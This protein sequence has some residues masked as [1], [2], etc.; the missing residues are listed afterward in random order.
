MLAVTGGF[1]A[2]V[3]GLRIS[4]RSPFLVTVL[5]IINFTIWFS[6][7]RRSNAVAF[8]L[9]SIWTALNKHARFVLAIALMS[10]ALALAYATNS[11]AGADAS[12]YVS[13]AAL[14]TS[15]HLFHQDPIADVA[16]GQDP[17][18]L[19][20]LGWKP[21]PI[22]G[23]QSP[24]YAP[25]LPML[26]ALPHVIAGVAGAS[27][28]VIVSAV[29]AVVATGLI[30][31]HLGGSIA[32]I[33]AASL[34]AFLPVFINQSIQP[35]SDVPVTAAWMLCFLL[36]IGKRSAA[37]G[38]ACAIAVLI[39][40][41]LAPLALVPLLIANRKIVFALPVAMAAIVLAYLQWQWYGSPVQS[42]YGATDQLF[43]LG[44][45]VPNIGRYSRWWLATAPAT[46]VGV[47]G[48]IRLRSNRIAHALAAFAI[49]VTAAY[50]IYAV[51]DEW[52]YLRF[53]LPAVATAAI[54]ASVALATW[55]ERWPIT[56]RVPLLFVVLLGLTAYSI[57]ITRTF[58]T[59]ALR[60]QSARVAT[61]GEYINANLP[62]T[63]VLMAG[64]Q[65]G[66]MRYYTRRSIIRW[67]AASPQAMSVVLPKLQQL[68]RPI[69]IVLDAWEEPLFRAKLSPAV[70]LDWPPMLVAGATH[71]TQIW[72]LADR[73]RF[74]RGEHVDTIRLP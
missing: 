17:Y 4:A 71:R 64:E 39:R 20:P 43:S 27:F 7:A 53:L 29:I 61:V 60:G 36:L 8:D 24:T 9:E 38:V 63:A 49:L 40:P 22:D 56:V 41:N 55:I 67:E 52:S 1:R 11:A 66:S 69:F 48:V 21:S 3:G 31:F 16:R 13:E 6:Q 70:P 18:L 14:L 15:G 74:Q 58:D 5:A 12:G 33:I 65:S 47:L 68:E 35:M 19:T 30:A 45:I 46:L 50:L 62:P 25:G 34:V 51:F 72:R 42:G 23:K 26:M 54:F 44:N 59:F 57:W 32:A 37:A 10:G 28:V 73:E 2:T